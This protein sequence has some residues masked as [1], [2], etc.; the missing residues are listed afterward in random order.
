MV[1]TIGGQMQKIDANLLI[2]RSL[3]LLLLS[4]IM[5]W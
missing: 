2:F 5:L 1:E 4:V 3:P